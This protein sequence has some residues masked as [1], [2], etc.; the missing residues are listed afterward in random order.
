[1]T[2]SR[3]RAVL[4]RAPALLLAGWLLASC[5]TTTAGLPAYLA[6]IPPQLLAM[7]EEIGST[8][9]APIYVRLFKEESTFEVW[10]RRADGSYALLKTYAIC[11]WSGLLG[12]KIAEG[13]HQ[14]PEG[15]YTVTPAQLNPNSDYHLSF[16]IGF[17][18]AFDR[19]LGRTGSNLMVHGAC[20]SAGCYSMTDEQVEEIYALVREAFRG[21]QR[22]FEVHAFPFRMTAENM[23]RYH[24]DPNVPF[25]EMLKLGYDHFEVTRTVPV[26]GVCDFRY[27]FDIDTRGARL[28]ANEACPPYSVPDRIAAPL[29]AR[30]AAEARAY[31]T[32]VAAIQAGTA[33]GLA[34]P[35][36]TVRPPVVPL[37]AYVAAPPAPPPQRTAFQTFF[38]VP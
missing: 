4:S 8:P 34:P 22:A 16:N 24:G 2:L 25:W 37:I 32:L 15:F 18:N 36:A 29:A 19:A 23:A 33:T 38:G 7:I 13:D 10:K 30:Q 27:V 31:E 35:R 14:A 11:A 9:L 28:V 20:S 3:L 17:P 12:P 21:G 6:P 5:Q 1:M 26:V